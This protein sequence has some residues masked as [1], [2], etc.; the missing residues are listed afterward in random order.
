MKL[1]LGTAQFHG[2][3][4]ASPGEVSSLSEADI[5]GLLQTAS[6]LGI[7]EFDTSPVYGSAE[8][9]LGKHV[10]GATIQSKV[11]P[12][13]DSTASLMRSLDRVSANRLSVFYFHEELT[14]SRRDEEAIATLDA[15][16]GEKFERLGASIYETDELNR[17]GNRAEL[18]AFQVPYNVA[19][20]RFDSEWLEPYRSEGRLFFGRSAL[21]QGVLVRPADQAP[22]MRNTLKAFVALFHEVCASHQVSPLVGAI[23]FSRANTALDGLIL[24]ARSS[25]ELRQINDAFFLAAP[26]KLLEDLLMLAPPCWD[27]VD[28]RRWESV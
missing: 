10:G 9:L 18:S 11:E 20:R 15:M 26:Q 7:S 5:E 28:P 25:T 19:D 12:G 27:D 3:Y 4:G 24:G 6:E 8:A 1:I 22:P 17:L 14:L 23:V 2:G 13:V 21:L 16:A